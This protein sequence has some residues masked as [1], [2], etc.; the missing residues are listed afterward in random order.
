MKKRWL[1]RRQGVASGGEVVETAHDMW[2]RARRE[3]GEQSGDVS[4]VLSRGEQ[5]EVS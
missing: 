5:V 3:E 2:V 4:R 1:E